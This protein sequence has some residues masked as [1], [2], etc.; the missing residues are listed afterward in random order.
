MYIV[1]T[2]NQNHVEHLCD[3]PPKNIFYTFKAVMFKSYIKKANVNKAKLM[4]RLLEYF[5]LIHN[6][7]V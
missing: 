7:Y 2:L 6:N 3:N 1:I 4:N 5:Y